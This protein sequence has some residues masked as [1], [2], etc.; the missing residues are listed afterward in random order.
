MLNNL[1]AVEGAHGRPA[2][3]LERLQAARV[4]FQQAPRADLTTI[5]HHN[6][7]IA[8][9]RAGQSDAAREVLREAWAAGD[10]TNLRHMLEVLNNNLLAAR[11]AGDA[12]WKRAVYEEFDR[13]L[14]R[15]GPVSPREQ[16]ALDVSQLRMRRNDG[17]P[18]R[19]EPYAALF[20]RLLR[21]LEQLPIG[22]PI[23]ER[24]AALREIRHDLKRAIGTTPAAADVSRLA[25][26]L[27][28]VTDCL[29]GHRE[30]A[31]D[32]YLETLPPTLIGPI[33]SLRGHQTEMDKAAILLADG[34]EARIAAFARL[35]AHLR[36][37]AEWLTEQGSAREAIEAWIILCDEYVAYNEQQ[38]EPERAAYRRAHR[39]LAEH[40]LDQAASLLEQQS[41][42]R[43]HADH[44]IGV[45]YFSLMLRDDEAA[46]AEWAR[47]L[48]E[49]MPAL[50]HYASWLRAQYV[51]VIDRLR[52]LGSNK[53]D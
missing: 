13:Q 53:F 48:A 24:I 21:D 11:E 9:V 52:F 45:A 43:D 31:V 32:A 35:F 30:E 10:S 49:L 41:R 36:E 47:K 27:H 19:P 5:L 8:L 17:I 37:K 25:A 6:L 14:T 39:H 3:Q 18:F 44:M 42:L 15:L 38:P 26:L 28:R 23:G 2:I 40:A 33:T 50:D 46:A 7:A 16:L 4:A 12:S 20:E 29:L 34:Q 51:W 1:A 22:T